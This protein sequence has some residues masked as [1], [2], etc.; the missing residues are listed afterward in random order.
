LSA[1]KKSS[2]VLIEC[3]RDLVVVD[4]AAVVVQIPRS[5]RPVP[6]GSSRS[7]DAACEIG[8]R[9]GGSSAGADRAY[10]DR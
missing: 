9:A 6:T 8:E 7:G 2:S 1:N 10:A 4:E 5:R 3:D